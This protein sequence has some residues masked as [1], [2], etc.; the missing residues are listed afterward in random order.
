MNSTHE[1]ITEFVTSAETTQL[2]GIRNYVSDKAVFYGF[3]EVDSQKIALAVDEACTNLIR[4]AFKYDKSHSIRISIDS[5]NNI[6]T[7]K[8]MDDGKPFNPLNMPTPDMKKYLKDFKKGGLGIHIMKLVMDEIEYI[9][10]NS[11]DKY[12][13]LILKKI[14]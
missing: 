10:S 9:P 3:N 14:S 5:V 11:N 1:H 8:I 6:F 7:I 4:H 12:N 13:T 2:E